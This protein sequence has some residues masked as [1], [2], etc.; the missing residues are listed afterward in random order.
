[1]SN[2]Q[3]IIKYVKHNKVRIKRGKRQE[4]TKSLLEFK[5]LEEKSTGM[6]GF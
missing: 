2:N 3:N 1:M 5:I 6:K 4:T